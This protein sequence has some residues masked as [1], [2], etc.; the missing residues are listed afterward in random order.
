[1]G[2]YHPAGWQADRDRIRHRHDHARWHPETP[3][4]K[5]SPPYK[6]QPQFFLLNGFLFTACKGPGCPAPLAKRFRYGGGGNH[7]KPLQPI[8]AP[9]D[10]TDP[11]DPES[12]YAWE[13]WKKLNDFSEYLWNAYEYDFLTLA[14][15]EPPPS[16]YPKDDLPF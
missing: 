9:Y 8:T 12:R 2:V 14:A 15:S 16:Q 5:N 3:E 1:M 6:K 11:I 13:L 10:P 7:M 4:E